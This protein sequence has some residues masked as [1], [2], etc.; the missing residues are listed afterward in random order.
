M[1][2]LFLVFFT[3]L[4]MSFTSAASGGL[5]DWIL[6]ELKKYPMET[7]L[8]NIG[9][10]QG[11]GADAFKVAVAEAERKVAKHILEKVDFIIRVNEDEAVHDMVREHYSAVL[12]DYCSWRQ[13]DPALKLE[14]FKVRNLSVDLARTDQ[15]TYALAF[16]ERDALK[17]I[18]ANHASK[19][20]EAIQQQLQTAKVFEETLDIDSAIRTYLRTY[21][22]YEALKEAEIVQIGAEYLPDYGK[23]F[24]RLADAATDTNEKLWAHR[25]VIKRVEELQGAVIVTQNDILRTVKFQFSKQK[26]ILRGSVSVHPVIYEDSEMNCPFTQTFTN[27]LTKELGWGT[28][29][30]ARDFKQTSPDIEKINRDLPPRLSSSCWQNGDEI[31]IRTTLRDVNTGKFLASAVVRFLK[32]QQRDP[33][34]Y[35]PRGYTQVQIEKKA[36]KP[37][38]FTTERV[39][40]NSGTSTPEVLTKHHFAPIGGL[41]VDVWTGEGYGPLS[42]TDGDKVKIFA[43]V[44]QP[45]YL[46]LLYTLADQRRT[47]LVDNYYI[48]P[49]EVGSTVEIGEFLCAAPFGTE[50]L[51]AAAR[52]EKFPTIQTREADGYHVLLDQDAES[53]AKSFRGL[54]VVPQKVPN[55]QQLIRPQ[56]SDEQPSFQQ[57]EAQLVLT[58]KAK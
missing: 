9:K 32:S 3:V 24:M 27:T 44:N 40:S 45:V 8:F 55:E 34:T 22:L 58:V 30:P 46:R 29:D 1:R 11:T 18:Y 54:K 49:S 16:I 48:G 2:K 56:P 6:P 5:P 36:F 25:Q 14:G 31:T 51:I 37:G 52:T 10:S 17:S 53:A 47:L 7:F 19:L 13:A 42:Y 50:F 15:V 35:Q 21:P 28:V 38:Y 12:E 23:A 4:I 43:R 20:R 41:T 57:S 33:L 39:R 26:H